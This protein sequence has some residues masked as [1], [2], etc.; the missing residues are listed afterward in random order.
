VASKPRL[1]VLKNRSD[2]L[3]ILKNGQR[4][5]V[6]DWLV[7]NFIHNKDGDFRC[8]WTLP[9]QVGPAVIRNRLKR[10]CRI[11]FRARL[12]QGNIRSVDLNVVF[13][14]ADENMYKR[15]EYDE[16]S[17]ILDRGWLLLSQRDLRSAEKRTAENRETRASDSG[18]SLPN[19]RLKPPR[20][21][22]P[23]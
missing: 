11:Y 2:F 20:G 12:Q 19:D 5:R 16:F 18:R 13:R 23:V 22:V 1:T 6:R 10:W 14:K 15:L 21:R 4:V 9:R 8:G 17:E 3:Y 7:L